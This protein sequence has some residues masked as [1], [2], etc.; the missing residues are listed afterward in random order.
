MKLI[1]QIPCLNEERVLPQTLAELPREVPGF[2]TVEWL[3]IDDGSTDK[4]VE[5]ARKNGVDHIIGFSTNRGLAA[6]FRAG[7]QASLE[8]GAEVIVHTDADNQYAAA[9]IRDLVRPILEEH[10]D[11]VIG[12]RQV[13][14][15]PEFG[16]LKKCLQ[17]L[18]SA[19][20]SQLSGVRV[21]DVTSGFRAYSREAAITL[22]VLSEYTYTHET[23]I[24]AGLHN[25]K[26]VSVPVDI[27]PKTRPSR[28][29]RSM[30]GYIRRS[31]ATILRIYTLYK[32]FRVF[33]LLALLPFTAGLL[34]GVRFLAFYMAGNGAGH[35]QSLILCAV[36]LNLSFILFLIG[37]LADLIGFN[38][39][40]LENVLIRMR[41]ASESEGHP[42]P[43]AAQ[44]TNS[45]TSTSANTNN[46]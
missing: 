44:S 22:N 16:F 18:G 25:L 28:L 32:A 14:K 23:V 1:I 33:T 20:V 38:R 37:V 26:V 40:L 39:R 3:I 6:A 36:L 45:N 2:D 8:C 12:D 21:P 34:L 29:F 15:H 27:N 7:L 10:A 35:I 9:S 43:Y 24:Q 42:A 31:T 5:V 41:T 4:T 19:L 11:M 17:R 30:G 13:W 46:G